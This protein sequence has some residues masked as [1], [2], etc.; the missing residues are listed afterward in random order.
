MHLLEQI[1]TLLP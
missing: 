1:V